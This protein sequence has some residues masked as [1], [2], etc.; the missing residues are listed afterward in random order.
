MEII[1]RKK[2]NGEHVYIPELKELYRQG[3]ITRREFMRNA[4]LLGMSFAAAST[5]LTACGGDEE[6]EPE[7]GGAAAG[8]VKR[9]GTIRGSMQV[10]R[11]DHPARYSWVYDSNV[12]RHV[13]EYLTL[14]DGQNITHPYL[15][16][17]WEV[18]DDLLTWDLH[19]RQNVKWNNGDD[20]IADDVVFTM[21]EWL[22]PDVGSSIL[23]LMSYLQPTGIE[24]VDDHLVRLHL[25]TAEIAVPEHLFH[26]PAQ[27]LHRG[28]EGDIVAQPICTGPFTLEEYSVASLCH[29][30][31]RSSTWIR[32]RIK[33]RP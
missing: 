3:R 19:L 2:R 4:C 18:S 5:F 6:E 24:K 15:L 33:R 17:K 8:A 22:N 12:T 30:S 21:K 16:G 26:Y 31:T 23:G 10:I 11:I 25:D 20:F 7:T 32:A 28:F 9:G 29:T 13:C 1:K 14:T 27:V